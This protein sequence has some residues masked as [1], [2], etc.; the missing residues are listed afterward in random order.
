MANG[1]HDMNSTHDVSLVGFDRD[2]VTKANQRL[3]SQVKYDLWLVFVE[4]ILHFLTITDVGTDVGF[5]L[6]PD[7]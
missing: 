3:G 4:Y 6:L 7:T 5:Y 1:F 2:I